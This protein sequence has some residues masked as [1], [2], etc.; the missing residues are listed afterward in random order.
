MVTSGLHPSMRTRAQQL[1]LCLATPRHSRN[2][3]CTSPGWSLRKVPTREDGLSELFRYFPAKSPA[4]TAT[5]VT[6]TLVPL[7]PKPRLAPYYTEVIELLPEANEWW[8]VVNWHSSDLTIPRRTGPFIQTPLVPISSSTFTFNRSWLG[9]EFVSAFSEI[10][11]MQAHKENTC[12]HLL[13]APSDFSQD[14][15]RTWPADKHP[16]DGV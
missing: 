11:W 14:T 8:S 3:F 15:S 1:L 7:G 9:W 10:G 12:L 13:L 4:R 6:P 5:A 16:E 2:S